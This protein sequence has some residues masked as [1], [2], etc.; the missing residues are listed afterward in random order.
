[1]FTAL[2]NSPLKIHSWIENKL[3]CFRSNPIKL[4]LAKVTLN[5]GQTRPKYYKLH[6]NQYCPQLQEK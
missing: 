5:L 1:M 3:D 6:L 4:F 2:D